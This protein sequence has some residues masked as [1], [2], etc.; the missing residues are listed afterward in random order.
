MQEMENGSF[1]G[2][3]SAKKPFRGCIVLGSAAIATLDLTPAIAFNTTW[4]QRTCI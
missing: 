3:E 2:Q 1:P 4:L